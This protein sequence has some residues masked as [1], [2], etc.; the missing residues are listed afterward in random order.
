MKTIVNVDGKTARIVQLD[1]GQITLETGKYLIRYTM[2]ISEALAGWRID[3]LPHT[4]SLT[5]TQKDIT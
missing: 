5:H 4:Q 1:G 2:T 3:T